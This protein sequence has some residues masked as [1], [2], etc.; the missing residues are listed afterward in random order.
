TRSF[1]SFSAAADEAAVSRLYGGIHFR[2]ANEDGQAAGI[3]IGD[4]AF[5]NYMQPKGDRSRK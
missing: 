3:L 1:A 2:A 4:W 5:T